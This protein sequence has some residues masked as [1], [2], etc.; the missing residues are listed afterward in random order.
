MTFNR[1]VFWSGVW[2]IGLGII[3]VLPPVGALLGL[4]V[5]N[6]FWPWIVAGFLWYTSAALIISSRDIRRFASVVY[7]E[8]LLRFF[9]VAVLITYG[10]KYVGVLPAAL[11][12]ISDFT[13][14]AVY[15][16]GLRR[17]VYRSYLSL[18]LN[19]EDRPR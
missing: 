10:L 18:L 15:L 7:W 8:A 16:V 6:P 2:N 5:P 19:R 17:V 14:G 11:F 3:L 9:A 4:Q 13:W 12:A 1:L